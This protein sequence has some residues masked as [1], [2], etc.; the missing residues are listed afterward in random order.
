MD[1]KHKQ[2]IAVAV[3][4]L[5]AGALFWPFFR[6]YVDLSLLDFRNTLP[7]AATVGSA[8]GDVEIP[9]VGSEFP[10]RMMENETLGDYFADPLG[11][12]LYVTTLD[13]CVG[14]CL[15]RWPPYYAET[16]YQNGAYGTIRREDSGFLQYTWNGFPLYY[17]ADDKA[18]G[19]VMGD[20]FKEVWFVARP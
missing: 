20:G 13:S 3:A 1:H 15:K 18:V 16:A 4:L 11:R 17:F 8:I 10:V 14:D 6:P 19:D 9:K 12:T 2:N 5:T 7:A